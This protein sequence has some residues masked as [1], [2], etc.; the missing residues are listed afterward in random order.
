MRVW[1]EDAINNMK[2]TC[3]RF[4]FGASK[5]R[6]L[7]TQQVSSF[8]VIVVFGPPMLLPFECGGSL[9][10]AIKSCGSA[11]FCLGAM[12]AADLLIKGNHDLRVNGSLEL[13]SEMTAT[14]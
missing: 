11:A 5:I 13:P 7:G 1:A 9:A 4:Q 10:R 8:A 14:P 12:L 6:L 2:K 3:L